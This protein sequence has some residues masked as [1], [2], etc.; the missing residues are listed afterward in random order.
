MEKWE[1]LTRFIVARKDNW[2][3]LESIEF[4]NREHGTERSQLE[5]K[6]YSPQ[7]MISILNDMGEV[8]WEL[9]H[10]QPISEIGNNDDIK[11]TGQNYTYSHAYFCVFKRRKP[12]I[13]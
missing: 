13:K 9:V 3:A 12:D 6:K 2:M 5:T 8:G 11:F 4:Y 1:Y 10:M 7:F